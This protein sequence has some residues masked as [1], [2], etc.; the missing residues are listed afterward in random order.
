M[1]RFLLLSSMVF[2]ATLLL[3][4]NSAWIR[5]SPP[6]TQELNDLALPS[7]GV[8]IA[9]GA[10]GTILRSADGGDTWRVLTTDTYNNLVAVD[11]SSPTT[12]YVV[13]NSGVILKTN[14]AGESWNKLNSGVNAN[15]FGVSFADNSTGWVTGFNRT[16]LKTTDGGATWIPQYSTATLTFLEDVKTINLQ[17]AV[18]VGRGSGDFNVTNDGGQTWTGTDLAGWAK[19]VDFINDTLGWIAGITA[20]YISVTLGVEGDINKTIDGKKAT[21]WK[22]IN[23]GNSWSP[24]VFSSN[25]Q[26]LYDITAVNANQA[27]AVGE[28]L[29]ASTNDGGLNWTLSSNPLYASVSLN[30]VAFESGSTG[31]IAGSKGTLLK[32]E[33]GGIT[34]TLKGKSGTPDLL[35]SVFFINKTTGWAAGYNGTIVKTADGGKNWMPQS[36]GL[37]SKTIPSVFFT[38]SLTGW[39]TANEGTILN[40][41]N[42]GNTWTPQNSGTTG[43]LYSVRFTDNNN[44]WAAGWN[45]TILHTSNGGQTWIP[46]ISGTNAFLYTV[47][48]VNSNTGWAGGEYG[49]LLLTRNGGLTWTKTVVATSENYSTIEKL[50]FLDE[51]TGWCIGDWIMKTTDGGETWVRQFGNMSEF[52]GYGS[53][54]SVY[55]VTDQTGYISAGNGKV[56]KTTDGGNSWGITSVGNTSSYTD[57]RFVDPLTGWIVGQN[58][59]IMKTDNG[60][61][62][63]TPMEYL[64]IPTLEEPSDGKFYVSMSPV[65]RWNSAGQGSKY[66]VLL[67]TDNIHYN[68]SIVADISGLTDTFLVINKRLQPDKRHEWKV[69]LIGSGGVTGNWS[70]KFSFKT[71]PIPDCIPELSNPYGHDE[72]GKYKVSFYWFCAF[73]DSFRIQVS[74]DP[75]FLVNLAVDSA[76]R[77]TG[78]YFLLDHS[79]TYYWRV[80][81]IWGTSLR[82]WSATGNFTTPEKFPS[83]QFQS[84]SGYGFVLAK[85]TL[86]RISWEYNFNNSLQVSLIKNSSPAG[87]IGFTSSGT[88]DWLIP[89]TTETGE[90][91]RIMLKD[92]TNGFSVLSSSFSIENPEIHFYYPEDGENWAKGSTQH[93]GWGDNIPYPLFLLL[94]RGAALTDTIARI[95]DIYQYGYNWSIPSSLA[96]DTAYS[97]EIKDSLGRYSASSGNFSI[98]DPFIRMISPYPGER[99]GNGSG[100]WIMWEDNIPNS[101]VLLLYKGELLLDTIGFSPS[102]YHINYRWEIPTSLE[103]GTDYR[104]QVMDTASLTI[105]FSGFFT[106]EDPYLVVT[107]PLSG[108]QWIIGSSHN[109]IYWDDNIPRVLLIM[110]YKGDVAVSTIGV[111]EHEFSS[112]FFW[113]IPGNTVEG[114]DYRIMVRDTLTKLT[115]FSGYFSMVTEIT[116]PDIPV[117]LGPANGSVNQPDSFSLA[118]SPAARAD[119]Y[120][121]QVSTNPYFYPIYLSENALTTLFQP[122]S[123]LAN[124]TVYYWHVRAFNPGGF[125]PWSETWSF[126]TAGS[127]GTGEPTQNELFRIYPNPF[128]GWIMVEIQ[129]LTVKDCLFELVDPAGRIILSRKLVRT[130][131]RI[132]TG[133][134]S[135]GIYIAR[136]T[137]RNMLHT[138]ILHLH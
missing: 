99:W 126:T 48:F 6:V 88:L 28:G 102:R 127:T 115:A 76:V 49:T 58:G 71:Q 13:G 103:A 3:A 27:V 64:N 61:G 7:P 24:F 44:G 128:S 84:P 120:F 52:Y 19:G 9:V 79:G 75:A 8:I 68:D 12:G 100:I 35:T 136:I 34:W 121:L 81:Q 57:L 41:T 132:E 110:L 21:V 32:T 15:L 11:F 4:Q 30:A 89:D 66:Q 39:C 96:S 113:D 1:K 125:S 109:S 112:I 60:G 119:S 53:L 46:Q 56:L 77:S 104:I 80:K 72:S 22:T 131:N 97:I 138:K 116:A 78:V 18:A 2:A 130:I 29:I 23:G 137:T 91:Y 51:K 122:V 26:W 59:F 42:G 65:L 111:T 45:G 114:N 98:E 69:R 86:F 118:W 135:P 16:V 40:T 70:K 106:I 25:A 133:S 38:D 5:Q 10:G 83:I 129:N 33:D 93:I 31:Y 85:G 62:T 123:G 90:N 36:S 108:S 50:F 47:F 67:V 63:F 54:N 124:G 73:A 94:Y 101:L 37:S 55:F 87:I 95:S 14:D 43:T 20:S 82:E 117:L 107:K 17:K 74:T 134:L 92:T 105:G